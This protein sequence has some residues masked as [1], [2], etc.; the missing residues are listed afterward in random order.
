MSP[1]P[2]LYRNRSKLNDVHIKMYAKRL[3]RILLVNARL[4][5]RIEVLSSQ[6]KE[7]S[8]TRNG[9]LL[10]K[11][12]LENE[13]N[14][15]KNANI[16]LTAML[17]TGNKKL[18]IL[19]QN[20][21]TC[22]PAL[23]T[24]SKCIPTMMENV[25]E[26]SKLDKF[27]EFG[28]GKKERLTK[29]VKPMVNGFVIEQ[30]AVRIKR[31][32]LNMS[33]IVEKPSPESSPISRRS[34]NRYSSQ[35][36]KV[37]LEPH[38]EPRPEPRSEPRSESYVRLK[39]VAALLKNSK[40]VTNKNSPR[41]QSDD[42]F[43]E[44]P[45]WLHSQENQTQNS[46]VNNSITENSRNYSVVLDEVT[47]TMTN[48]IAT[49]IHNETTTSIPNEIATPVIEEPSTFN[50]AQVDMLT[51]NLSSNSCESN[52]FYENE[53]QHSESFT[54]ESS[55]L[56]NI[57]C[58]KRYMRKS[59]ESSITSDNES[60]CLQRSRRSRKKIDYKENSLMTKLRR[61]K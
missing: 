26:I 1:K 24:L 46:E 31:L 22:V 10:E 45:S 53:G 30:P 19:E 16:Q 51:S 4:R 17:H 5:K 42:N 48:E 7:L 37:S 9:L 41:R 32:N 8:V 60:V 6:N 3:N 47:T 28:K 61:D 43:G 44:G 13:R 18:R 40:A 27:N 15:I 56:R 59:S 39:D 35:A 20:L 33:P 2:V 50:V 55:M 52:I 58:R 21:Q 11:L 14:S 36:S 54:P 38:T 34:S 49:P 12:K 25:H 29:S 23:V 57:T